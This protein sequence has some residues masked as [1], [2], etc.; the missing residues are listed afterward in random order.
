VTIDRHREVL[1][2]AELPGYEAGVAL[3]QRIAAARIATARL[4]SDRLADAGT[5]DREIVDRDIAA[6][7]VAERIGAQGE[8]TARASWT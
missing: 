4:A 1:D 3:A 6:A 5:A 7:L 8:A 2:P